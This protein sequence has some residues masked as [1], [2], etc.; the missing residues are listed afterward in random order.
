MD[1]CVVYLSSLQVIYLWR[2]R[3]L[4]FFHLFDKCRVIVGNKKLQM[5]NIK[6]R[7]VSGTSA[8]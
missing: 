3:Y 7:V 2:D 1:V 4:S 8:G 5:V 6:Q